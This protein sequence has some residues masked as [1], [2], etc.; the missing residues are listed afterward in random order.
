MGAPAAGEEPSAGW[1]STGSASALACKW[2]ALAVAEGEGGA[3]TLMSSCTPTRNTACASRA[4][5][6]Q[7]SQPTLSTLPWSS[8][9]PKV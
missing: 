7:A 1:L 6:V 8:H 3:G 4:A 9:T 2:L 5:F